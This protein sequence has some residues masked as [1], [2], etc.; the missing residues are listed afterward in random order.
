MLINELIIYSN[1]IEKQASFYHEKL[2]LEVLARSNDKV[3]LKMG[4]SNLV[5]EYKEEF[6]P[7]HFA[8]NIPEGKEKQ[9]LNWL[10]ERVEILIVND[11]QIHDFTDWDAKAVYF[12]DEDK[13]IVELIARRDIDSE[14]TID[15]NADQF[16]QVSEI[17][18]PTSDIESLFKQMKTTINLPIYDGGFERFC[19]VGNEQGLFIC[20]NK[21]NRKWYP[22]DDLAFASPFQA[23]ISF[24]GKNFSVSYLNEKFRI[25]EE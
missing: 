24:E 22:N 15:F 6:T 3:V 7:Y 18:I 9:A 17:G 16:L 5:I 23:R 25:K 21:E 8:I 19:A 20:I 1:N 11:V 2:G 13:N 4:D 10:K 14:N 12:Y